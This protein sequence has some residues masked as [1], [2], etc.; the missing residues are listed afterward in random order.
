MMAPSNPTEADEVSGRKA[1]R[2]LETRRKLPSYFLKQKET[3]VAN[4]T[5]TDA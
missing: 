4:T 1:R 2:T 3:Q 5:A